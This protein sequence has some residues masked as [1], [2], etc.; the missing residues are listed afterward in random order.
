MLIFIYFKLLKCAFFVFFKFLFDSIGATKNYYIVFTSP[1]FFWIS[2]PTCRILQGWSLWDARW[3]FL[4]LHCSSDICALFHLGSWSDPHVFR[5]NK[6][7]TNVSTEGFT[8]DYHETLINNF[9]I[10]QFELVL[11]FCSWF[12]ESSFVAFHLLLIWNA[13]NGWI[14]NIILLL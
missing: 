11:F 7:C 14:K 9:L 2:L 1:L 12:N 8:Q 5:V 6:K 13:T 10:S 3:M 4:L